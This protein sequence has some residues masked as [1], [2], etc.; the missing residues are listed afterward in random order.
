MRSTRFRENQDSVVDLRTGLEWFKDASQPEFP[1]SWN[2]IFAYVQEMNQT[3]RYGHADWR[4]PN[5]RE[6]FSLISLEQINPALPAGH[7]FFNV[8]TSYYWTSTTCSPLPDQ[9]WYIHLGGARVFKGLKK[10]SYMLWPLRTARPGERIPIPRTG[11]R[12][13]ANQ[14]GQT[15]SCRDTG[16]DGELQLGLP[17]PEPRFREQGATVVDRLTGLIWTRNAD[18]AQGTVSWE[19]AF[20]CVA[21]LNQEGL[22]GVTNWRLPSIRE[23]ESLVDMAYHSPALPRA[24]PFVQVQEHY[25]S[26]TTSRYDRNYAWALYLRDGAL[27]VGYKPLGEFSVWAVS[28][29]DQYH[30]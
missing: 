27:G 6:L 13:C 17:A 29:A 8:F 9:A 19:E 3:G 23:L 15:V 22:Q 16:Q 20:E 28:S 30:K 24:H 7:P 18:G 1:L 2:E 5:R 10:A 21:R 25:W 11:Q 14:Q 12:S 26:G 4:V